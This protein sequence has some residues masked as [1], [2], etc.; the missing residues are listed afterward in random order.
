MGR[1]EQCALD[2]EIEGLTKQIV[3]FREKNKELQE[4]IEM[5]D[6]Q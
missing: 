5:L 6:T 3:K 4:E 2:D 1:M